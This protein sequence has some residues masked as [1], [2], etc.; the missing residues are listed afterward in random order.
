[1]SGLD[2]YAVCLSALKFQL[3]LPFDAEPYPRLELVKSFPFAEP[4]RVLCPRQCSPRAS[5]KHF[6]SRAPSS[7]WGRGQ[8]PGMRQYMQVAPTLDIRL[9][10]ALFVV[11]RV[12]AGVLG[13]TAAR[14]QYGHHAL[15]AALCRILVFCVRRAENQVK[16][17]VSL[18]DGM[19]TS[20]DQGRRQCVLVQL[21]F[22][23]TCLPKTIPSPWRWSSL[24]SVPTTVDPLLSPQ[25]QGQWL[26][27]TPTACPGETAPWPSI[28][29]R[30][31]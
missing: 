24:F 11:S 2:A 20:K 17:D 26:P 9:F 31:S 7:G 25:D 30:P 8:R 6:R 22:L 13:N 18:F 10:L 12:P 16:F 21:T 23:K 19:R 14:V 29:A 3:R 15:R 1:M 27:L 5:D 28:D 4:T